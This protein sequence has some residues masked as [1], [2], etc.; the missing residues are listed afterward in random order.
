MMK[1]NEEL[2]K[3]FLSRTGQLTEDWYR[4]LDKNLTSGVYI[5]SNQQ[6][7]D[8]LKKQNEGF[9]IK[10][11]Q[12]FIQEE[13]A[14]LKNFEHWVSTVSR[15]EEHVRTPTHYVVQEFFRTQEQ[16]EKLV[17]DFYV[18]HKET[19]TQED[20]ESWK[21][22]IRATMQK[23]ILWFMAESHQY[24]IHKL[25]SQQEMINELSS[26][27]ILLNEDTALL[28]LVGD[29]DTARAKYILENTLQQCAEKKVGCL[30]IDLS[31]VLVIDTMVA[32][33]LFQLHDALSL[34]GI[35]TTLAGIRPE[36]AQTAVQLG[37]SFEKVPVASTLAKALN[38]SSPVN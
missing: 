23:V 4:T 33:Q 19:Y 10:F 12:V 16:Y 28:P 20:A 2:Y 22:T 38:Y 24:A 37:L 36:I 30:Y 9:H 25:E 32:H 6:E 26:P 27:V 21:K 11:C 34:L 13:E 29:I 7:I 31:G 1:K 3:F 35:Q 18:L 14:F 17:D 15:D 5:S 8:K